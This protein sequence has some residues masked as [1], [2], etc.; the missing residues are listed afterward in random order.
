M[1]YDPGAKFQVD[2]IGKNKEA[3]NDELTKLKENIKQLKEEVSKKQLLMK[4]LKSKKR[5]VKNLIRR[6]KLMEQQYGKNYFNGET[7]KFPFIVLTTQNI[8]D[9]AV[10]NLY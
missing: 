4:E 5:A 2:E 10:L 7:I 9:N 6:N 3:V 1:R 8:P